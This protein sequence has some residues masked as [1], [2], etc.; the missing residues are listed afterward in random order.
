LKQINKEG[1]LEDRER[2]R[3]L[4]RIKKDVE[5]RDF[6]E[7][8]E[9]IEKKNEIGLMRERDQYSQFIVKQK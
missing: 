9:K 6:I 4:L 3:P 7:E 1:T 5:I 2:F 8:V